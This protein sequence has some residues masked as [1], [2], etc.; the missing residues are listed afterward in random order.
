MLTASEPIR[1]NPTGGIVLREYTRGQLR[2]LI[3]DQ[4]F[5]CQTR[6]PISK[7]R[8]LSQLANPRADDSD[9]VLLTAFID[10]QLAAHIGVL[11]DRINDGT[12]PLKFGWLTGWW[13]DHKKGRTAAAMIFFAAMKKYSNRIAI[14]NFSADAKRVF[15]AT[16]QF[17]ALARFDLTYFILALPSSWG[18]LGS[19][20]QWLASAI[21]RF[22]GRRRLPR[23]L[24]I[25]M[26]DS[27]D[28]E[29]ASFICNRAAADHFARDP[30]SWEWILRI[31]WV[32]SNA[33]DYAIQQRYAFSAFAKDFRHVPVVLRQR[34]QIIAFL[35]LVLRNGR[36]S[37]KYAY[38]DEND[39]ITIARALHAIIS[40]VRPWVFVSADARLNAALQSDSFLHFAARRRRSLAYIANAIPWFECQ[41]HFGIGDSV[42][43]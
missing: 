27:V 30:I 14:S 34:N 4:P 42:F 26:I 38:Y 37:L 24:E 25:Q 15:D 21:D 12:S 11:P 2:Q 5:W 1:C 43:S 20:T 32:A 18:F 28:D 33:E 7:R 17:R 8:V 36:L 22:A 31:P 35:F 3:T 6:L 39:A 9:T 16:R 40:D 10:G 13:A 41:Q 19:T 29:L 23:S